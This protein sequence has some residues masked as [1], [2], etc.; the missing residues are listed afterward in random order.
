MKR[1]KLI[2]N[3]ILLLVFLAP[4]FAAN[5]SLFETEVDVASRSNRDRLRGFH[6]AFEQVLLKTT[7]N[8]QQ[9]IQLSKEISVA[10]VSRWVQQYGFQPAR[11]EGGPERLRVSFDQG[12][13]MNLLRERGL[14]FWPPERPE[15]L[16]LLQYWHGADRRV[17]QAGEYPWQEALDDSASV[18]G[19]PLIYPLLDLEDYRLMD[20]R[21]L[22]GGFTE[23]LG[24][25]AERYAASSVLFGRLQQSAGQWQLRWILL[26]DGREQRWQELQAEITK[27]IEQAVDRTADI[28]ATSQAMVFSLHNEGYLRLQVSGIEGMQDFLAVREYLENVKAGKNL[29]LLRLNND[30]VLFEL[31]LVTEPIQFFQFL[32]TDTFLVQEQSELTSDAYHYRYM[33]Q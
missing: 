18:R 10:Q 29:Q 14:S 30:R 13:I 2:V 7:G 25:L 24:R 21:A 27:G 17:L 3:G 32:E 26:A 1:I 28:L 15:T 8:R 6:D 19:L 9:T 4:A 11:A 20:E 5:V 22:W 12:V 16:V 33:K 31:Q 23:G